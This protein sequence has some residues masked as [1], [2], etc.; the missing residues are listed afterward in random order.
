MNYDILATGAT[1]VPDILTY[2]A[3]LVNGDGGAVVSCSPTATYMDCTA[4]VAGAAS[5]TFSALASD[6]TAPA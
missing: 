5:F 4:D 3:G 6:I 2:L 1:T